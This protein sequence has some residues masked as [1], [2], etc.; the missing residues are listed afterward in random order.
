MAKSAKSFGMSEK[1]RREQLEALNNLAN[2]SKQTAPIY[3]NRAARRKEMK[4][5]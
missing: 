3:K 2:A 1:E 5:R 4:K